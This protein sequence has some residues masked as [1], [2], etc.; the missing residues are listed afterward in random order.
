MPQFVH[1]VNG[2][3]VKRGVHIHNHVLHVNALYI[4]LA[5]RCFK[6]E[7]EVQDTQL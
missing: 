6:V 5:P 1:P 4:D 2:R 3:G 7:P